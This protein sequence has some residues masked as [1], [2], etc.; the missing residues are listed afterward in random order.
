[1]PTLHPPRDSDL[2][3]GQPLGEQFSYSPAFHCL[4]ELG[5]MNF[6]RPW[7]HSL[8]MDYKTIDEDMMLPVLVSSF[9]WYWLFITILGGG[10]WV[11]L[12][13]TQCSLTWTAGARAAWDQQNCCHLLRA[14]CDKMHDHGGD[15]ELQSETSS[16]YG[17]GFVDC[18][19][20][21]ERL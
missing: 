18:H 5:M 16:F 3:A 19:F 6:K 1:M 15:K 2:I 9:S 21:A 8:E 14:E 11:D 7:L 13:L 20:L 12:L 17:T 10:W 4:F